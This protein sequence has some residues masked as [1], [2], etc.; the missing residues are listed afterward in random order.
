M[1]K[2]NEVMQKVEMIL[3]AENTTWQGKKELLVDMYLNIN[4]S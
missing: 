1:P 2:R 3:N 4:N